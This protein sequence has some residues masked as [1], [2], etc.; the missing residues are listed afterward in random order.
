VAGLIQIADSSYFEV[1]M[2]VRII[3]INRQLA[4]LTIADVLHGEL[5]LGRGIILQYLRE[6]R[7][8]LAGHLC[9][10]PGRRVRA[11][12]RLQIVLKESPKDKA[13]RNK[14]NTAG[15]RR[16]ARHKEVR[17]DSRRTGPRPDVKLRFVDSAIVVV[18][19]PAGLTT[20]RH[21]TEVEEAGRRAQKFL[22]P[23]LV[24]ILPDYLPAKE[25]SG[26]VRAVHRLDKETTGLVVLARTAAA[27]TNLGL[28]FRAHTIQREYLAL[29]RGR[30]KNERIETFLVRD[31]GDGRRGSAVSGD[32]QIAITNI[33]VVERLG[34]FT[35]VSCI[36][37]TGRTHQVRIHLGERG[38]PLCGERI[39]D[40]PLNG[41]PLPDT[42]DARRPLL[43]AAL[44][45]FDH[46]ETG[47]KMRWQAK[48]PKEM[49]EILRKL[50]YQQGRIAGRKPSG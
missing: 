49:D 16:T 15:L 23:T 25:R 21:A 44:L 4:G 39:Y 11:G 34:A 45:G 36:L 20:V 19:K 41:K 27:E 8:H 9:Q 17:S 31:R 18:D 22:P 38:T 48:V 43:H 2:P 35:L 50:R 13:Q 42:S 10:T 26:R 7:V 6:K 30:A 40:R 28:Q 29:V 3:P 47:Q 37:E 33:N 14:S 5:R 46:P 12:Q 32:G 24:D 1:L